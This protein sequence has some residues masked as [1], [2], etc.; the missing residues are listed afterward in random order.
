MTA[1][2]DL[3]TQI[4]QVRLLINDTDVSPASVANFSDEELQVFLDLGGSVLMAASKACEGMAAKGAGGLAS[5]KI[6]DY[7]YTN[8]TSAQWQALA[9]RYAMQ[10]AT[11]PYWTHAEPDFE[12]IGDP[13]AVA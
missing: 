3:A 9:D 2:Y 1:T 8:K 10:D 11:I 7:A 13:D 5:E 4:G 6:G 12:S